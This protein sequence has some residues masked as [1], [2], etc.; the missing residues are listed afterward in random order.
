MNKPDILAKAPWNLRGRGYIFLY[1]FSKE[2]VRNHGFLADYQKDSFKG[3]FGTVMLVDYE[4]SDAGPYRELLFVPGKFSLAS[5]KHY[6]ISKIYVST[7]N[8]VYNGIENWGIPKEL[9]DFK[10][11][12]DQKN[13]VVEVSREGRVFFRA[14][15]RKPGLF[16]PVSTRFFPLV[17][18]QKLRNVFLKTTSAAKGKG[19]LARVESLFSDPGFFPD[20]TQGKLLGT[21]YVKDFQMNFGVAEVI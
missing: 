9:A 6:S 2:F 11:S 12:P 17:L 7:Y 1:Y 4:T 10:F 14:K 21:L 8:S 3:G 15:I 19:G 13:E 18:I 16:F 5:Q 20:I